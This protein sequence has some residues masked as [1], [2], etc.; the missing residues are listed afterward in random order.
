MFQIS[1]I[2]LQLQSLGAS[3]RGKL[4]TQLIDLVPKEYAFN[5]ALDSAGVKH[6]EGLIRQGNFIYPK[7]LFDAEGQVLRSPLDPN[8][9]F[10]T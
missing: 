5:I 7:V 10:S 9:C 2:N 1:L 4:C 8:V 6:V 3:F